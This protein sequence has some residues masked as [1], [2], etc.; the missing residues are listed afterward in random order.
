MCLTQPLPDTNADATEAAAD[1][2]DDAV[3][4]VVAKDI[5]GTVAVVDDG[6]AAML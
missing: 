4:D 6:S 2:D 5:E 1:D 3:A